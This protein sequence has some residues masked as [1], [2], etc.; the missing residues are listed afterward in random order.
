M[1]K[2]NTERQTIYLNSVCSLQS[3]QCYQEVHFVEFL[4]YLIWSNPF[5]IFFKRHW[6]A[7]SRVMWDGASQPFLL[8]LIHTYNTHLQTPALYDTV[9]IPQY[10]EF[11][12]CSVH[13]TK[14]MSNAD[15]LKRAS[16]GWVVHPHTP[17]L[18]IVLC[19]LKNI[20]KGLFLIFWYSW[21]HVLFLFNE[22]L[23]GCMYYNSK[24]GK[25]TSTY[26][27]GITDIFSFDHLFH[28]CM[29]A[30]IAVLKWDMLEI[31]Q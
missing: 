7:S 17:L 5:Q 11:G 24:L 31:C 25:D 18:H 4:V 28:S 30:Q 27:S 10:T 9:C 22:W 3:K 29:C 23:V 8:V 6:Y 21:S 16:Q 1:N 20:W 19:S 26:A 12:C 15:I 14:C 2:H 13:T